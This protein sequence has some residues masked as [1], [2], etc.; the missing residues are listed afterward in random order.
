MNWR[1]ICRIARTELAV[2]FYSPVA[3]L[4]LLAFACQLGFDFFN[5]LSEIVKVEV[6]GRTINFSVTAGVV[7]GGQGIY[8]VIQNTIYLYIPLLTMNLM[9]REYA[10]GSVKLLYSSPIGSLHIIG[11]K[12]LSMVVFAL[13]FVVIMAL[14]IV[15]LYLTMD[16]VDI[17]LVLAGLLSMFLLILTYCSIGLFMST[18]TSYQVVA[19]VATLSALAFF[20]YVGEMG[21]ESL[22]LRDITYWLS[23]KGR[24]SEMVGGLICS[25]D[26][27]YFISVIALFFSFSVIK[28]ENER[29]RYSIKMKT[30]RYVLAVAVVIVVGYISSRPGMMSFYDG[31]HTKQRTLSKASQEV[32]DQLTGPLTITTYVNVFDGSEF[33]EAEPKAQKKDMARFKM[34]TRFK[35][36]I[37]MNYVY[38]YSTLKD[39]ALYREHPGKSIK[40]IATVI[41]KKRGVSPSKLKSAEELKDKIDL[42]EENYRFVRVVERGTGEQAR[43]RLFDDMFHHPKE[44]EISASLKKMLVP[45]V[46]VGAVVGHGERSMTRKGDSDYF[47][48]ATNGRFRQS[49]INQGFDVEELNLEEVD[50]VP[51]N[52]PILIVADMRSPMSE[53]ELS[54]IDRFIERGGNMMILGDVARQE[55]MNPLLQKF[56]VQLLP[57]IVAQASNE[58]LAGD[59]ALGRCGPN[60]GKKVGG[61]YKKMVPHG[62]VSMPAAVALE[63]TD[64]TRFQPTVLLQTDSLT[65]WIE[66][67]TTDFINEPLSLDSLKGECKGTYPLA[68]AMTRKQESKD[69]EQR[70]IVVGD[71]DCFSNAEL[72]K[73][74]R[75]GYASQNFSM[76]PNS[77]SWL[78]YGE[79]PVSTARSA[80]KDTGFNITPMDL[81]RIKWIYCYILPALIGLCGVAVWLRRRKH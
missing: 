79:F 62:A 50:S 74:S 47:L 45:P 13:L 2:L 4:L 26:I 11:G 67:Q 18:L 56:G 35:P 44:T 60:A 52:I 58:N 69:K 30:L 70:I 25:D 71:A 22:Y 61:F 81:P 24:A 3:W 20:N 55:A 15:T 37:E 46:K 14:P 77:F 43:L 29:T 68:I 66:Y 23:I 80:Y 65:N 36:E 31:T 40:E 9:S 57:G 75:Q 1:L 16:Y 21:Q 51:A 6:S 5:I 78:C 73:T 72:Q 48:F 41:A 64:T 10:T 53:K 7:L 34:Y 8:E 28:L 12:F 39:S 32:M 76:I 54:V 49:L 42:S 33:N 59:L 63:V 17:T 27:I 38:Y 19:A